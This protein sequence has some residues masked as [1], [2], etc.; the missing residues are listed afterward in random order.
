MSRKPLVGSV[1]F[2]IDISL[3]GKLVAQALRDA[4]AK[5]EVHND[6]FAEGTLDVEWLT[7]IGARGW[8]ALSK[9][10]R[11]RRNTIERTTLKEANVRAFFLTQQGITGSEMGKIFADALDGMVNRA[12]SQP[13]PF[14]YTISRTGKF[15]PIK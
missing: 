6:H 10:E 3:G 13:A 12:T 4:G 1:T 5:V 9:D 2:F 8:V 11:I 7:T 14:I 15:S